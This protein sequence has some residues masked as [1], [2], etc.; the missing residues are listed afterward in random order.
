[1][2]PAAE[3]LEGPVAIERDRL[4]PLVADEVLDQLDL[5]VL[6]LVPEVLDRL[7]RRELAPLEGLVGLD[8]LGH[9]LLDPR[10]VL[11]SRGC[12]PGTRCRSRSRSRS[13]GPIEI[14]ASGQM[15][16]TDSASTWA[17]SWRISSSASG[18]RSVTIS[19]A[20]PPSRGAERS[21]SSP[22]TLSA[23]AAFASPG[24]IAAAASAPVAP[25]SSSSSEPSGSFTLASGHA[26]KAIRG[27]S[28]PACRVAQP[29]RRTPIRRA[30]GIGADPESLACALVALAFLAAL[31][32]ATPAVAKPGGK[33]HRVFR[34]G[35]RSL[36]PGAQGQGRS[37]P[38][39][40]ADQAR[41]RDRRSTAS[42]ARGPS[43]AS[44]S[45][46]GSA[47]GGSTAASRRRTRSGS[48]RCSSER[49]VSGGYFV[50]GY[51]T[52]TLNL[53]ARRAGHGH[54]QGA[55]TPAASWSSRSPSA[56]PAPESAASAWNGTTLR[57][58][59]P[60]TATY[61]MR[62]GNR[63]TARARSPAARPSRS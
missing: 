19:I 12:R 34:F 45:S 4:R 31:A 8:V 47:A 44:R 60:P 26:A 2:R 62:L 16:S 35:A 43:G 25:G 58:D 32:P 14:F 40:R 3:V 7:L 6:A 55:R 57:R 18:L 27:R 42:T 52:P 56:S 11:L 59:S 38:A 23:S 30:M 50:E 63:G 10:Q 20:S 1:M 33:H 5:V 49:R 28:R 29:G 61:Q 24:P 54:G 46:S 39:A 36:R 21:R 41:L 15:S 13:A 22:S 48:G 37:L 17:A 51:V 9:P 53:T